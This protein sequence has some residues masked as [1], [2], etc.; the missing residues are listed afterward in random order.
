MIEL[1]TAIVKDLK[2]P[3]LIMAFV[4]LVGL[5]YLLLKKEKNIKELHDC[6]DT[7][8]SE[9]NKTITK[10]VTLVEVLVYGRDRNGNP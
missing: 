5:F 8:M 2:D 9:V 7:N 6:I 4:V 1:L 10:L 3:F